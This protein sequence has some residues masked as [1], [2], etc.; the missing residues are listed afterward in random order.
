MNYLEVAEFT[1]AQAR[2]NEAAA[3]DNVDGA[4]GEAFANGAGSG[5]GAR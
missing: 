2:L 1:A 4:V 5:A 3:R